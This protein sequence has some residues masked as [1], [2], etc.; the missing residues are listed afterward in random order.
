MLQVEQVLTRLKIRTASRNWAVQDVRE[1]VEGS[2]NPLGAAK[3]IITNLGVDDYT[4]T[5]VTEARMTAQRLVDEALILGDKFDPNQALEKAALKIASMRVTD[6]WFFIKPNH[7]TVASTTETRDGVDVE[8]KT[9]GSFKKGS[10]QVL[11]TALYEKHKALSN[12]EIIAIFMKELDMSKSGAMTY[13]Y[14]AK[15]AAK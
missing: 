9:D 4:N 8:V 12:A 15:K 2:D 14:N 6:P 13:F 3:I 5:D 7:S 10:K 11:A 1:L